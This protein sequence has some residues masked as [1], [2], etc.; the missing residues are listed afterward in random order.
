M[1]DSHHIFGEKFDAGGIP[2]VARDNHDAKTG[3]ATQVVSGATVRDTPSAREACSK[4]DAGVFHA[5]DTDHKH[6]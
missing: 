1:A 3:R 4:G 2:Q 6:R 5:Y